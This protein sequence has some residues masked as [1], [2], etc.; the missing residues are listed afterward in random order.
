MHSVSTVDQTSASNIGSSDP[1]RLGTE[2]NRPA[3]PATRRNLD[4]QPRAWP[5]AKTHTKSASTD[6]F[7]FCLDPESIFFPLVN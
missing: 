5:L 4:S 3:H 1:S 7:S 2:I 6:S